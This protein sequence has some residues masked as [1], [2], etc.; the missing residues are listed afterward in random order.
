MV[1]DI[2]ICMAGF[3]AVGQRFCRLLL[4]KE[5]ELAEKILLV[6]YC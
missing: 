2:R 4:E 5:T 6:E 3:G 1:R